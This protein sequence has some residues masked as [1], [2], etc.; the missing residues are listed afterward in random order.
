MTT[1]G[2]GGR[3]GNGLQASDWGALV[4][5]DPRLAEGLLDRLAGA[6][7]PAFVEP[8]GTA[9]TFARARLPSRPLDRLW[10][11]PD[12]AEQARAVVQAEVADLTALL[13]EQDPGA[14]AHGLVQP[15]P[16]HAVRRVLAPPPLPD[17]PAAAQAPPPAPPP[18]SPPAAPPA[19]PT[20]ATPPDDDEVFRQIIAGFDRT[21]D[22]PVNPWPVSEDVGEAR[23]D[24][25]RRQPP[26]V[27]R[28]A[29]N[30]RRTDPP[31][32]PP[33]EEGPRDGPDAGTEGLPAWLEPERLDDEDLAPGH[34]GGRYVPPPPP[35][36]PRLRPRTIAATVAAIVG[37]L[38]LFAPELLGQTFSM[39][40]GLL[41]LGLL[42]GGAVVLLGQVRDAPP[43]DTGPDDGAVV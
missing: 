35:P 24:D 21:A 5:V 17:P 40:I 28:G 23:G 41:G 25:A 12:R 33:G 43:T 2:K 10:V 22:S 9:D 8:A 11:D 3:R 31:A 42:T 38:L 13:A 20:P 16:R 30:R 6:G 7:V 39:G 26:P 34:E 1:P 18:G 4:D 14:T 19:P 15:V 32:P 36:L 37:L 29:R 27:D